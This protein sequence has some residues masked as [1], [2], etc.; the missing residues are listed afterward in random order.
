M[1]SIERGGYIQAQVEWWCECIY[2]CSLGEFGNVCA[3]R[4]QA[5]STGL[6]RREKA[7]VCY[8]VNRLFVQ[9]DWETVSHEDRL[10]LQHTR[11]NLNLR[12][13]MQQHTHYSNT[14]AWQ[15]VIQSLSAVPALPSLPPYHFFT[16][17]LLFAAHFLSFSFHT[18]ICLSLPLHP[19]HH[20]RLCVR[21]TETVSLLFQPSQLSRPGGLVGGRF[22]P[23]S[24]TEGIL[25]RTRERGTERRRGERESWEGG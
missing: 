23:E 8:R 11:V 3:L 18:Y 25:C 4:G 14:W 21:T 6:W 16:D 22:L 12:T 20:W 19:T 1:L 10:R 17:F 15:G 7:P 24:R 2:V 5:Q 9:W 13:H